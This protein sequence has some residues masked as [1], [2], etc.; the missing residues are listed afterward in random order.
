MSLHKIAEANESGFFPKCFSEL[1]WRLEFIFPNS[2]DRFLVVSFSGI[3]AIPLSR[4]YVLPP[5]IIVLFVPKPTNHPHEPCHSRN[6]TGIHRPGLALSG[7]VETTATRHCDH[8]AGRCS[9]FL[10]TG[11]CTPSYQ[12]CTKSF[13]LVFWMAAVVLVMLMNLF[14]SNDNTNTNNSGNSNDDDTT[15]Y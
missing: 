1:R 4:G 9:T 11:L 13:S 12:F 3:P 8:Y 2:D 6:H 7:L 10:W 15:E 14:V 5:N